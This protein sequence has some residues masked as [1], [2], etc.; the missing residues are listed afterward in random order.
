MRV[1]LTGG[2]GFKGVVLTQQLID[3]NECTNVTIIDHLKW[4]AWPLM[5]LIT[6]PKVKFI[7]DDVRN[8]KMLQKEVI[9][10]DVIINLAAVV[11][12]PACDRD[13]H[14]AEV[15]NVQVPR[16]IASYLSAGQIFLHAS[17]GSVYGQLDEICTEESPCNPLSLYGSTKLEAEKYVQDAG[18]VNFRFATAFG[19][20]P[21]MRFD[22]VP[23]YFAWKALSDRYMVVYQSH[24]R[25]TL[26]DVKDMAKA[27]LFGMENY[28]KLSGEIFNVGDERLNVTKRHVVDL[29][30]ELV[31]AEHNYEVPIFD[32]STQ[33]DKDA[34]DYEV[35]Y[36]KI[37][38]LGYV[39]DVSFR[40]G[41]EETIKAAEAVIG[42]VENSWRV[43]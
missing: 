38:D 11:G 13:P 22:V 34:R 27:Y 39:C 43:N 5:G 16:I 35:D 15:T 19:V 12:H 33:T 4:G 30:K 8:W 42:S 32:E 21:C 2:G 28:S 25:R 20:S 17:T 41:L 36:S 7:K 6:H 9:R 3:N 37:N 29:V 31:E 18:G 26:I 1:L 23:A 10:H 24:A 40:Q 14:E